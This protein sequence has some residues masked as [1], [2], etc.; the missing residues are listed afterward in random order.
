MALYET[1]GQYG[2]SVLIGYLLGCLSPS[3]LVGK[4]KGYDVYRSGSGNPGASNTVIMAGKLA[5]LGVALTDILKAA[6]SWWLCRRLFPLLRLAGLVAGVAAM[7]GHMYPVFMRFHGGK[8]LACLGGT[9]LAFSPKFM[10][11]MLGVA[12]L[13][14]LVTDYVC[15]ATV[16]MSWVVPAAYGFLTGDWT[17][18]VIWMLPAIPILCKHLINFRRIRTGEELRF[19]FLWNRKAELERIGRSEEDKAG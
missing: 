19:S 2:L 12:F 17:G 16:V 15:I 7:F 11:I 14:A 3:W 13:V 10:L 5:G 9:A 18:A 1:Y 6:G 8:G 4:L